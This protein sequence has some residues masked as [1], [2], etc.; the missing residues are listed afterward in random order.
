M[1][2]EKIKCGLAAITFIAM[3]FL[4]HYMGRGQPIFQILQRI[5]NDSKLLRL[6]EL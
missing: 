4:H 3:P 5:G 6:A 2:T 1:G